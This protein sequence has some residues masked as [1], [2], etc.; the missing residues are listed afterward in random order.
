M[1][2]NTQTT[3]KYI[4]SSA[5]AELIE[6]IESK[7]Y[8]IELIAKHPLLPDGIADHPDLRVCRLGISDDAPTLRIDDDKLGA[9]YPMDVP[10]NVACTGRYLICNTKYAA[11]EILEAA[12][13]LGMQIVH[14]KQGYAKCSCVI[15]DE[16]SIITYDRGL[17]KACKAAGLNVLEVEAGG[18]ELPG[19]A[20][21]FIGGCSGRVGNEIV[22]CGDLSKHTDYEQIRDYIEIRGLK[23]VSIGEWPLRD[24]G[25]IV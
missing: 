15:V 17:A 1:A 18:I 11:A 16:D 13:Q 24:I 21:G 19:Y 10:Y 22:F 6:Y 20:T 9:E 25:S 4:A 12:E 2:S 3:I 8:S 23:C 5:P 14:V 7:G